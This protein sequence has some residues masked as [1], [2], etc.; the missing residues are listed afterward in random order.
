L[1]PADD[2][3]TNARDP[4]ML[5]LPEHYFEGLSAGLIE[6]GSNVQPGM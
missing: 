1:L 3:T 4:K 2:N 6:E 5:P